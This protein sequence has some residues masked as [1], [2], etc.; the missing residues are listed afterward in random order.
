M[1]VTHFATWILLSGLFCTSA[2]LRAQSL[3]DVAKKEDER[4][5]AVASAG[6]VYTNKDLPSVPA[7]APGASP[8]AAPPAKGG[9]DASPDKE[10]KEDKQTDAQSDATKDKPAPKDQAYWAERSKKLHDQLER[11]QTFSEALQSRIN[12]LTT[13][14]VN[15]SDPAQRAVIERDRQKALAELSNL[16]K[17]IGDDRKALADLEEEARRAGV[18][19]GWLR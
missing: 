13:D 4:R 17:Q 6:K 9:A 10:D 15:R 7:P 16:K 5:K 2:P 18:P 12:A 3:G 1:R 8:A 11:D 14:F 19:P